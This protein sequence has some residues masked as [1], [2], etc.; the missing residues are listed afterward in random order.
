MDLV[1]LIRNEDFYA[2]SQ[3]ALASNAIISDN[4]VDEDDDIGDEEEVDGVEIIQE[5]EVPSTFTSMDETNTTSDGNWIVSQ[6]SNKN[7]ITRELGKDSF[8]DK[9]ELTRAIKLHSIRTHK[10]FEVIETRPTLW[11]IRCK[12]NLQFGCKWHL[13]ACKRKRSGYFEI[14]TYTGPHTCLHSTISQ[15]HPNL[16]A[17]LIAHETKHLIK[18]QPSISISA[19]IAEI[20]DKL[21]Y[22]PSYKKVWVGKQ[23][24][25]EQ[26]FGNWEESYATL[27]KFLGALQKFNPG[28][29]VEWCVLRSIDEEHVE[30]R[31]VF[32]AFSPSIKGFVHC[33]SVISIDGTHLY[34]KYKG[35]MLIAMG[36]DEQPRGFHRYCL[37]HFI[38][39]FNDK[40]HNSE[41]KA[42]AYR[43][44]SQN[45]VRKFNSTM[46]EIRKLNPKA[47]QWLERHPLHRWT[48]AHDGGRR[49][50]AH[51]KSVRDF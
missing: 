8:K 31:R 11:S 36:V 35:K 19:L 50:V 32:W 3:V 47:R 20:I 18:E 46:E 30:F 51:N 37:R 40:F 9:E 49:C 21:G 4:E 2:I 48:L 13:C 22:T 17:R 34:G 29:I 41:L 28:T 42:L 7:D 38:S 15:D 25:I 10:Q 14:T 23:K 6:S 44:G 45:Q 5:H 24:A 16:D 27:P 1:T 39:N 33:R 12:L 26:V 43:A